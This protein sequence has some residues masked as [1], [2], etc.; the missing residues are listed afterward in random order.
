M[1]RTLFFGQ[2][3]VSLS[4]SFQRSF[5]SVLDQPKS[6][7]YPKAFK[8]RVKLHAKNT[9]LNFGKF[10]LQAM[11]TGRITAKQIDATRKV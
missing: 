11:E 5:F 6:R 8:G 7:K 1:L 9:T 3:C 2:P 4:S 10:G